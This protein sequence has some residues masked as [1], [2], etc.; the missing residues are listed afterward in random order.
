VDVKRP[1]EEVWDFISDLSNYTK[2]HTGVVAL[3]ATD[4]LNTGSQLTFKSNGLGQPLNLVGLITG[5][6]HQS[7]FVIKSTQG[8]IDFIFKHQ[9]SPIRGGT[10]VEIHSQIN[11]HAIL[12]LAESAL[13]EVSDTRNAEDLQGL[14]AL[15][16][17]R[18]RP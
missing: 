12:H 2:W 15:L 5:T 4:N 7:Y 18:K 14:K 16:E 13:Q 1:L 8:P 9:L 3:A 11:A 6:D 17:G 10:R